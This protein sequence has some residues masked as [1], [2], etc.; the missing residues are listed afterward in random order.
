MALHDPIHVL[1]YGESGSG[2]STF[3]AT[4]P[5]PMRVLMWD[6]LGKD[7]PFVKLGR[8]Q[9]PVKEKGENRWRSILHP[10]KDVEIARI[11]YFH[12]TKL[13]SPD[14]Y[15][16]YQARILEVEKEVAK[17]KIATVVFDS[18]TFAELAARK[19]HQYRLNATARDPRQ[20]FAGSTDLLEEALMITLGGFPCNLV[21]IAHVDEDKD[22]VA[23]TFV[24]NP[25]APGRL[26]KRLSS[27]YQ[28]LY[29][30]YVYRDE[31]GERTYGLQTKADDRFNA[32]SQIGAPDPCYPS[33]KALWAENGATREED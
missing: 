12:N 21:V 3:A 9:D 15:E 2:K 14:A 29:R 17:E 11:D 32:A 30:Q 4:F 18:I 13:T 7:T 24:R 19:L 22:E 20:F 1:V 5:K 26:R 31:G 16:H 23:G 25:M 6:P 33:Y 27:G 10:K 8:A 28:E